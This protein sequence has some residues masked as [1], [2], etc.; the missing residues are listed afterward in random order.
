[1]HLVAEIENFN[2]EGYKFQGY[3]VFRGKFSESGLAFNSKAAVFDIIDGVTTI[4]GEF[5]DSITGLPTQGIKQQGTDSGIER[6]IFFDKDNEF[7]SPLIKG[8]EYVFGVNAYTYNENPTN[9]ISTTE[10]PIHYF[11]VTYLD[12]LPGAN[13]GDPIAFVHSAGNG[14]W[15]GNRHSSC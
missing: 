11:N 1:M 13:F 7:D 9:G 12:T 3:N 8:K 6:S 5:R 2:S 10:T 4:Y 14:E 15:R